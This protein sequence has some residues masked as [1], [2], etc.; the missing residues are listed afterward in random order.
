MRIYD[1]VKIAV[2][3]VQHAKMRSFLTMLGIVIGIASVILLMAIGNSARALIVGQI[4]GVGSNLIFAIPGG[5]TSGRFS[6]PA[7][8]QGVIIKTLLKEDAD[9]L[10]RDSSVVSVAPEVRGQAKVVYGNNDTTVTFVG[11]TSNFFSVRN[12]VVAVGNQFTSSDV[13]SYEHVIVLGSETSNILF[14]NYNPIGKTVR[15]KDVSFRVVGIL[16]KKGVGAFGI[17]Q[18]NI[19][20]IPLLVAQKQLLGIDY[21]NAITIQA[22]DTYTPEFVKQRV[23]SVIRTSHRI[24]DP[25]KDDFTIR[26][27][28]DILSLL[29]NIMSILTLFLTSIAFISLVVGGIGIMNIM[30]VSVIERTREI[31]L[32]K[33]VG[34]TNGDIM[35]QFLWESVILT[36]VGGLAGI[37]LGSLLTVGLYFILVDVVKTDWVFVLPPAAIGLAVGVST[38]TGLVFGLYPASQAARKSPIEALRYE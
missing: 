13:N 11:V 17:D 32:R 6:A 19:A 7:S 14:G 37:V 21:Y 30:L 33:A 16:E 26:T 38:F 29:G 36:F 2:S 31:G 10:S 12:F 18:D 8:S 5:T 9:A 25:N 1:S 20:V 34:A 28:E 22:N 24:T 23:T 27:Q 3:G 15:L 4:K 35:Q